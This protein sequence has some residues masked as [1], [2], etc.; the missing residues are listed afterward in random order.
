MVQFKSIAIAAA[1]AV[2]FAALP[3]F[4]AENAMQVCGAKY[5]AAK[6]ANTLP[7]GQT[8]NQFLAQ[9]RAA[10]PKPAATVAPVKPAPAAK[11]AAAAKPARTPGQ[12]SA[13]QKAM[14][15]RERQCGAQWRADSAA[16]KVP[17]GMKW[18]QYWSACNKRMK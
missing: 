12:P 13:A 7:A 5:Q 14:Y 10:M 17:A 9:C 3:A 1:V 16:K 15:E 4:A 11:P 8:W 6:K 2:G 18:P